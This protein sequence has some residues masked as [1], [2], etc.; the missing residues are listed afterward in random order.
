MYIVYPWYAGNWALI[1]AQQLAKR[2]SLPL[3]VCFCLVPKF[4]EATIRQY[5]FMLKGL[6]EVEQV[7]ITTYY[8]KCKGS[9]M[10]NAV[11]VILD[12]KSRSEPT[13]VA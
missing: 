10:P 9:C 7:L 12:F 13:L 1:Y 6:K 11:L 2:H 5:G 4:L 8:N 3:M